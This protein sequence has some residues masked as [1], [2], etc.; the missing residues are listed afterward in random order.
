MKES[1]LQSWAGCES[2]V[3]IGWTGGGGRNPPMKESTGTF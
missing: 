1:Y 2:G 3:G